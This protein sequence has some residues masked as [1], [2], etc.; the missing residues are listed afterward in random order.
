MPVL[1]SSA[2]V[3][4][5]MYFLAA[6]IDISFE[7]TWRIIRGV[8]PGRYLLATVIS[9]LGFV[10]RGARWRVMLVNVARN[11]SNAFPV[12]SLRYCTAV[13]FLNRFV[14]AVT[15][16]RMGDAFRAYAYSED[17]RA[18]FSRS[19]GTV[20]ADRVVD[21]T[22]VGILSSAALAGCST[23]DAGSIWTGSVTDSAGVTIVSNSDEPIWNDADRWNATR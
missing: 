20:L 17:Q 13:I 11:R 18:S 7:E 14:N 23:D 4:A 6:R 9:F 10:C 12:P 19:I 2:G 3:L 21:L 1:I 16:F 15:G 22:V 5:V 8:S